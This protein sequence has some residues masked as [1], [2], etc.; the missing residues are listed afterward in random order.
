MTTN[1]AIKDLLVAAES[2]LVTSDNTVSAVCNVTD[3]ELDSLMDEITNRV[4]KLKFTSRE[5]KLGL[6]GAVANLFRY[7]TTLRSDLNKM[8]TLTYHLTQQ[9]RRDGSM[10]ESLQ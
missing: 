9:I 1:S 2:I 3:Y 10:L 7:A 6:T 4:E 8:R 5:D